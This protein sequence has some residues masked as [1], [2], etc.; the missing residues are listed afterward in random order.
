MVGY[1][2]PIF[3][4]QMFCIYHA[5]S[6]RTEAKWFF[7]IFFIPVLGSLFYLYHHFYS[8]HQV[9]EISD[10]VKNIIFKSQKIEKLQQNLKF[11]DTHS[12]RIL[13]ADEFL[14]VGNYQEALDVYQNEMRGTYKDDIDL[15]KKIIQCSYMLKEYD[16]VIALG[17]D[18]LD[19]RDFLKTTQAL[20]IAWSYHYQNQS[21][22][23]QEL[24]EK[25]NIPFTN[26]EH[27]IEYALFLKETGQTGL[28]E[29]VVDRM[30]DEFN[31]MDRYEQRMKKSIFKEIKRLQ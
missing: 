4:L 6:N 10:N 11:S 22:T 20:A 19:D 25:L 5:Y 9:D 2:S 27:R 21:D 7:I 1:Y 23:A 26:Y 30:I 28:Q 3:I 8:R 14:H 16:T 12:N 17:K 29:T 18:L 15:K 31:S 24:F 13:L